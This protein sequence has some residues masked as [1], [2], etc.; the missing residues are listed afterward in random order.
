[1]STLPALMA[2]TGEPGAERVHAHLAELLAAGG[3]GVGRVVS[4]SEAATS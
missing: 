2:R 3:A 4:A 1:M